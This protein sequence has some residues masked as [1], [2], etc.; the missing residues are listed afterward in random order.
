MKFCP[1]CNNLIDYKDD[2]GI[3]MEYC[4]NCG[5]RSKSK[6]FI[7]SSTK[8]ENNSNYDFES[9][10]YLKYDN[11]LPRTTKKECPNTTCDSRK[12]SELQESVFW[13]DKKTSILKY[14]C[15]ICDTTWADA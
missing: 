10:K 6:S 1:E 8:Y 2:N 9:K 14:K 12:K 7:I 15:V 4:K 13:N 3:L 5:F 11:T